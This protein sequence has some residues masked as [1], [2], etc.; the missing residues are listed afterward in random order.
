MIAMS[1][2][3]QRHHAR[4]PRRTPHHQRDGRTDRRVR[5]RDVTH[6]DRTIDTGSEA[7]AGDAPDRG[8]AA[9]AYLRTLARRRAAFGLQAHTLA[10][11]AGAKLAQDH[12]CAQEAT[13]L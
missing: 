6:G 7:T 2:E 12:L 9:V 13:A 5:T 10:R 3:G 8:A 1:D 11:S 4:G